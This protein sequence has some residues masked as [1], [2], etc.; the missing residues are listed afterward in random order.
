MAT[1]FRIQILIDESVLD[2][3]KVPGVLRRILQM[4]DPHTL[5]MTY[6]STS[7]SVAGTVDMSIKVGTVTTLDIAYLIAVDSTVSADKQADIAQRIIK[8][9]SSESL[10]IT[11]AAGS[12]DGTNKV[13]LTVT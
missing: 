2:A 10:D 7:P 8:V 5:V 1:N 4:M 9:L 3:D 12:A 13:T 6:D 11:Y